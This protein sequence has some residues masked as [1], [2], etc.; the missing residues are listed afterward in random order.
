[1]VRIT[2]ACEF[3]E[4]EVV[5]WHGADA[6]FKFEILCF[7]SPMMGMVLVVVVVVVV[8]VSFALFAL[9]FKSKWM[10]EW[11]ISDFASYFSSS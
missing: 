4:F 8:V 2:S 3:A 5:A 10:S 11:M 1:M 6:F 9:C 7:A